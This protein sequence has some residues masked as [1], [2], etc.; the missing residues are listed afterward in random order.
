MGRATPSVI[1]PKMYRHFAM[2]TVLLTTGVAMFADGENRQAAAVE[3]APSEQPRADDAATISRP[4]IARRA[5][6]R[7]SAPDRGGFD[8]FDASF[9]APM[10]KPLGSPGVYVAGARSDT[11]PTGYSDRYLDSLS[12]EERAL[13]L[14]GLAKEGLLSPAE[15]ER[16]SAALI[17][18]SEGRSGGSANH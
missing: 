4:E 7:R 3:A 9:G 18:A 6:A 13:L 1:P 2:V 10:T 5:P 14:D 16:K 17:A 8:G 11:A 12:P 15:R